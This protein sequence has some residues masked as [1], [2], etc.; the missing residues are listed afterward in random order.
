MNIK[1]VS[2]FQC[3]D[4]S[5]HLTFAGATTHN[6]R[7]QLAKELASN[8]MLD[9]D[10]ALRLADVAIKVYERYGVNIARTVCTVNDEILDLLREGNKI[11]AIKRYRELTQVGLKEAKDAVELMGLHAGILMKRVDPRTGEE[12]I[13]YPHDR[14]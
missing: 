13:R 8:V 7:S 9:Q 6:F 12:S 4:G 3:E 14:F 11:P 2:A 1:Q 10:K 5:L